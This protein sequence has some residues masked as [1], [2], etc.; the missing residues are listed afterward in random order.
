M[1]EFPL[2]LN[3][4]I[5]NVSLESYMALLVAKYR[6]G[7]QI[8]RTYTWAMDRSSDF[9]RAVQFTRYIQNESVT[10]I[11]YQWEEDSKWAK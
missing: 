10:F 3:P 11:S 4:S 5:L 6:H 7:V 1:G 9:L 8:L 2:E